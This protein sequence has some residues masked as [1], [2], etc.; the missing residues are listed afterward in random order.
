MWTFYQF[1]GEILHR[2]PSERAQALTPYI[3]ILLSSLI[4]AVMLYA[5]LT[6][7]AL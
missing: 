3:L 6:A 7:P 5:Y 1:L 4:A 2:G